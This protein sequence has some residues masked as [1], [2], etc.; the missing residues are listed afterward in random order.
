MRILLIKNYYFDNKIILAVRY[1]YTSKN[2]QHCFNSVYE[3]KNNTEHLKIPNPNK[4]L[5]WKDKIF[6]WKCSVI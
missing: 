6:F 2:S 3:I 4:S 5:L 1:T